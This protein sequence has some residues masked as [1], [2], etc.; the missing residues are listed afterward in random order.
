MNNIAVRG[1]GF[2]DDLSSPVEPKL[3]NCMTSTNT[4]KMKEPNITF[5]AVEHQFTLSKKYSHKC[6]FVFFHTH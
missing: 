1:D 2:V 4:T 3:D 5:R 6:L